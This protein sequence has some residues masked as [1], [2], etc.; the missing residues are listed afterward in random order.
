MCK[1]VGVQE[2]NVS[3]HT[4]LNLILEGDDKVHYL[5]AVMAS[6]SMKWLFYQVVNNN[7][8]RHGK[9]SEELV[10]RL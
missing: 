1:R 9:Q 2:T 6:T 7:A 3:M 8:Y 5:I 10:P 4:R